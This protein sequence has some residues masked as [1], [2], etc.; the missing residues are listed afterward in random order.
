MKRMMTIIYP[1]EKERYMHERSEHALIYQQYQRG[2]IKATHKRVKEAEFFL[3][4]KLF[5]YLS[6]KIDVVTGNQH[7]GGSAYIKHCK[8]F[9]YSIDRKHQVVLLE[10]QR[11]VDKK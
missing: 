2:L 4:P 5:I 7:K 11:I 1:F 10:E 9:R 6:G 8:S 3:L